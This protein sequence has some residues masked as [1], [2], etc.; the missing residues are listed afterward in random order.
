MRKAINMWT[1]KKSNED[2]EGFEQLVKLLNSRIN[3]YAHKAELITFG[4]GG[5]ILVGTDYTAREYKSLT[6]EIEKTLK[7]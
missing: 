3:P 1:N 2:K 5:Y 7:K 6:D 4:D